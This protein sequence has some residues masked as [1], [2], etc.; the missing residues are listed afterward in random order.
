MA[1]TDDTHG[2]LNGKMGEGGVFK[3][4]NRFNKFAARRVN[5]SMRKKNSI[6]KMLKS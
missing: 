2:S 1:F 4:S 3:S 6:K 5:P